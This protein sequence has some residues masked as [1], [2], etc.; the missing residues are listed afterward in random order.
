VSHA[1]VVARQRLLGLIEAGDVRSVGTNCA[2]MYV[3]L[4]SSS[5]VCLPRG[6]NSPSN[7]CTVRT[8]MHLAH[9]LNSCSTKGLCPL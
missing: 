7:A 5:A 8:A 9:P 3:D 2:V 6:D 1:Q 4:C